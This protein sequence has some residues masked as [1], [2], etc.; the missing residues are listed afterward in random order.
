MKKIYCAVLA[1]M[2]LLAGCTKSPKPSETLDPSVVPTESVTPITRVGEI[3]TETHVLLA[4]LPYEVGKEQ[5]N[6]Y[7]R[8]VNNLNGEYVY[9]V[10]TQ[11]GDLLQ[12]PVADTVLY[13]AE[14]S[15]YVERVSFDY[16]INGETI[17]AEQYWLFVEPAVADLTEDDT[18]G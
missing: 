1:I 3:S 18:N 6:L 4:Q 15:N 10:Y 12:L 17:T 13:L 8:K 9:E 14:N 7:Y 16:E 2:L 11:D 5:E